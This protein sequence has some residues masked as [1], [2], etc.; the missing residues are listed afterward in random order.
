MIRHL[1]SLL[2]AAA[3]ITV[4]LVTLAM[5]GCVDLSDGSTVSYSSSD[6][7]FVVYHANGA[8]SGTVP[9]D[10]THYD[11][12]AEVVVLDN[13]GNL[14]RDGHSFAG[15]N[16][17]AD[18]SGTA[19]D[20]G[21]SFT[22]DDHVT[23]HAE[24]SPFERPSYTVT[25]DD[26]VA[27]EAIAVP[28]DAGSYAAGD[29]VSISSTTPARAGYT[30]AFW[31]TAAD[32]SGNSYAPGGL[33]TMGVSDITLYAQWS[34]IPVYTVF[35]DDNVAGE[36]IAVPSDGNRYPAGAAV[37]VSSSAPIRSGYTFVGWATAGGAV[38]VT[39][40][41]SGFTMPATA[42]TLYAQWTVNSYTVSYDVNTSDMVT[43]TLASDADYDYSST[44]TVAGGTLTR[45]GYTFVGWN[46]AADGSGTNYAAG[47]SFT[48]PA[49]DVVLY[50]Q[51]TVDA[52]TLSYAANTTDAVTG[53]P[54][55][56]SYD[57]GSKATVDGGTPTRTGYTVSGWNTAADGNGTNY[58]AGASFTMPAANV[59]LYAQWTVDAY[60]VSYTVNTTET[61]TGT[62]AS[63]AD[64]E[65]GSAV[66]VDSGTLTR[67]G[68][69]F[70]G[71][72]TTADGSGTSYV[73][74]ASFTMPAVDVTLYAQWTIES[75]AVGYVANTTDAV[76]G[77]PA[78]A[79][80]DYGSTVTVDA[81]TP[82]RTGYTFDGWNTAADG[83]GTTY[84]SGESITM[85]AATVTLYAQWDVNGYNLSYNA[86]TADTVRGI[87]LNS[88][89]EYDSTVTVDAGTPTRTGYTFGGWNTAADGS[90]TRYAAGASFT[91]PA[92]GVTLY[93]Q[94]TVDAYTVR[95][96]ANAADA[97]TGLP[98]DA[99]YD[100]GSTVTVAGAP[101][102]T[103][104]TFNGWN[105]VAGG[106]GT[107]YAAGAGFTMS[108]ADVTLYAQWT[109]ASYT[110]SYAV[111]TTDTV[112]GTVASDADYE[113]GSTVTVD[114]GTLIR[115][116]YTFG[117]W[118]TATDGSGTR[119][120]ADASFT[121]PAAGVTLYA[122]WTTNR[123]T[124]NYIINGTVASEVEYDY[125]STVTLAGAP[126]RTGYTF[127][128]WNTAA[129]GSG[130]RYA[131]DAGFT[132]PAADVT[133]YAQWTIASYTLSYNVNT[134]DAVAGD[135]VA[136]DTD[137]E[138]G[139]TVTVAGGTLTRTG[140]TF[141]GWNTAADGSGTSYA[142]G[143]SFTMP[144]ADV[145]LY[146]QWMVNVYKVR[147][148]ANTQHGVKYHP[149]DASYDYGSTVTVASGPVRHG[150]TFEGWNS[151]ADGS[152]TRY[153]AGESFTMPASGVR[154]YAQWTINS[155]TLRYDVNTTDAVTGTVPPDTEHHYHKPLTPEGCR[156]PASSCWGGTPTRTGY[157]LDGWA[158]LPDAAVTVTIQTTHFLMPAADVTLYAQWSPTTYA[159]IYDG[160]HYD[161]YPSP[162][163]TIAN[164]PTGSY[165][166]YDTSFTIGSEVPVRDN[167]KF[168][169]WNTAAD[170]GGTSYAPG[171]T[172][173]VVNR[174]DVTLYAQWEAATPLAALLPHA[175]IATAGGTQWYYFDVTP[176]AHTVIWQDMPDQDMENSSYFSGDVM[177]TAYKGDLVNTY[178]EIASSGWSSPWI[179]T[180]TTT[181]RVYLKVT[182]LVAGD[183]EIGYE[184]TFSV[185]D[186]GQ[187]GGIVFYVDEADAYADWDYLEVARRRYERRRP[188]GPRA[189]DITLIV[190]ADSVN[191]GEGAANTAKFVDE[192]G[193]NLGI[194]G[195]GNPVQYAAQ[196]C[197]A[198]TV[199]YI[200]VD[201]SDWFLPSYE[202]LRQVYL[203]VHLI[204]NVRPIR[205]PYIIEEVFSES[206]YWS[207]SEFP[208]LSNDGDTMT[209]WDVDFANGGHSVYF[210]NQGYKRSWPHVVRPVRAF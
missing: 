149:A 12:G 167:A 88:G 62:V 206:G 8:H 129:D 107:H 43:G 210:G 99:S 61:V 201:F 84:F 203:N 100:Y 182:G 202:E 69:T 139:S 55:D 50:A 94:W 169:E 141:S 127:T 77:L 120:T 37:T 42:V 165:G 175:D 135:T 80:H 183:Y 47:A 205:S 108:T 63:D 11:S 45:T 54:A 109:I 171:S 168:V 126:I 148:E 4:G 208:G 34:A 48:M 133:L 21:A 68:Y 181:E 1:S 115:T 176:K 10:D 110:V 172:Y 161:G 150:Y 22:I 190:D 92:A 209:A 180:P 82:T 159:I 157:T 44:V 166:Y 145:A 113:Y 83:S 160:N 195:S 72:N 9:T 143:A 123:Y 19:H 56:A 122:Q 101:T 105:S 147:Y 93:A 184:T 91:M 173:T 85:P 178:F 13:I 196:Y 35:Y 198:L 179:F 144:G 32:G 188:W 38:T 79:N 71:W 52:Y 53:L 138:Y 102:R 41:D 57:Y 121:M 134:T 207:S 146:A 111:N 23:L 118:N 29:T 191:F 192:L 124:L 26:N 96:D 86:N 132:M 162:D 67:T 177:V 164:L 97:V 49:V 16:T 125:G 197:H 153:A 185:G 170:G 151:A 3:T 98:A 60:T 131:A 81:G 95:Y 155:Y 58:A 128:G 174:G 104:Y 87:P 119:Y 73:A 103:G 89:H 6:P 7:H 116:G 199:N 46:S 189:R 74:G 51:W 142:G 90:G 136:S 137:Y 75:Y 33:M 36:T 30:F 163:W 15:W 31:N 140:Y 20:V 193:A 154:L 24:W 28:S 194:D 40:G 66:T 114:S 130:T 18:S 65:Y 186:I 59:T 76:T 78:D 27:G 156:W 14:A 152:G 17:E 64:Y 187:A 5:A 39:T 25:Y 112:T 204:G 70:G 200:G 158:T 2:R 117:G 106:S